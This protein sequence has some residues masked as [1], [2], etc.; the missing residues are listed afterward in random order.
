VSHSEAP[1]TDA[2]VTSLNGFQHC[3]YA[4]PFTAGHRQPNG[5]EV[6][7]IA[8]NAGWIEHE[9]GPIVQAW[10]HKFMTDGSWYRKPEGYVLFHRPGDPRAELRERPTYRV[11]AAGTIA[12]VEA[13]ARLFGPYLLAFGPPATPAKRG[14]AF[15]ELVR[16]AGPLPLSMMAMTSLPKDVDDE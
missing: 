3:G 12:A 15:R 7:L 10:A 5:D 13:A 2:E 14:E 11:V 16:R 6:V 9:G 1:W 4:H 8:T